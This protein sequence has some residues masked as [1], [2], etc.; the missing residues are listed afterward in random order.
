MPLIINELRK[1]IRTLNQLVLGSS[2]SR[3]TNPQPI[4]YQ[5]VRAEKF[6]RVDT[7]SSVMEDPGDKMATTQEAPTSAALKPPTPSV[8]RTANPPLWPSSARP[9][10]PSIAVTPAAGSASLFRT[11][12]AQSPGI[13]RFADRYPHYPGSIDTGRDPV[14]G[15]RQTHPQKPGLHARYQR[16]QR[17]LRWL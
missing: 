10:C 9:A 13:H 7:I 1:D 6:A 14:R 5:W 12:A 16:R 11:S 3:G 15:V 17:D 2:P 4:H 8:A